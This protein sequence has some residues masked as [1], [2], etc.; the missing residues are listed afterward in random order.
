MSLSRGER[1]EAVQQFFAWRK[2]QR[3]TYIS[4]EDALNAYSDFLELKEYR[5]G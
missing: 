1:I 2:R 4:E 5:E 3:A